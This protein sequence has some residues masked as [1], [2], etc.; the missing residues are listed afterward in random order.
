MKGGS[1]LTPRWWCAEREEELTDGVSV[2]VAYV[3]KR[4]RE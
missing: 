3:K 4:A 1:A 2:S